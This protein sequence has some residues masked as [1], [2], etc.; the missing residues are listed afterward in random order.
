MGRLKS[1]VKD[2]VGLDDLIGDL[3]KK[4][5]VVSDLDLSVADVLFKLTS[6]T[7]KRGYEDQDGIVVRPVE[8]FIFNEQVAALLKGFPNA[9]ILLGKLDRSKNYGFVQENGE[10]W[11]T[12]MM[13]DIDPIEEAR[14]MVTAYAGS[15]PNGVRLFASEQAYDNHKRAERDAAWNRRYGGASGQLQ[16]M[17]YNYNQPSSQRVSSGRRY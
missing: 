6:K 4:N 15:D 12:G 5:V 2:I 11:R 9:G 17:L 3:R 7:V 14:D 16:E 8:G 1:S 10:V 13:G